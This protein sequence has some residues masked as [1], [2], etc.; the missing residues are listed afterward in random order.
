MNADTEPAR[1]DPVVLQ[2]QQH[3]AMLGNLQVMT[4]QLAAILQLQH[5]TI[6]AI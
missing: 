2:L 4:A 6:T 3:T 5:D 1:P